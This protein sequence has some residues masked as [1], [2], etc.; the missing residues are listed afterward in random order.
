MGKSYFLMKI[1]Q[2]KF[3][4]PEV[5]KRFLVRGLKWVCRVTANKQN[6]FY[7]RP[8][9]GLQDLHVYLNFQS[10]IFVMTSLIIKIML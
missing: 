5:P 9:T 6:K 4:F 7:G 2:T 10:T 1:G 8:Y 3:Y